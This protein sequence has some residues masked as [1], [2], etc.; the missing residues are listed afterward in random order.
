MYFKSIYMKLLLNFG[1]AMLLL[2]PQ[3]N[4]AE[5]NVSDSGAKG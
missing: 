2:F 5:N 3:I 1:I 4:Y